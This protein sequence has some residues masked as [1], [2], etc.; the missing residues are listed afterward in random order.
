[1]KKLNLYVLVIVFIAASHSALLAQTKSAAREGEPDFRL[2]D[3]AKPFVE[4]EMKASA[5]AK[6]DLNGD[7]TLDYILVLEQS[8][9]EDTE[10]NSRPALI[11]V[12]DPK[13]KLSLAARNRFVIA[14]RG[15]IGGM[16][17]PFE[18][19][20]VKPGGF[21]ITNKGGFRDRWIGR[22]DFEFSPR[23]KTWL[24]AQVREANYESADPKPV[25][26]KTY[27][28]KHF[29]KIR[30]DDFNPEDFPGT[31]TAAQ[32]ETRA[33]DIYTL[34][35]PDNDYAAEPN[36]VRAV[37][38]VDAK[39]PLAGA[40][41]AL[42]AA[43]AE[44][45][46]SSGFN[47]YLD[48]L[49]FVSARIKNGTARLDFNYEQD[50]E[51]GWLTESPPSFPV[52]VKKTATQFPQVERVLMCINGYDLRADDEGFAALDCDEQWRKK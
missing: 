2:P 41:K 18:S 4:A 5:Y 24:L 12:R 6:A 51:F 30:F 32:N 20:T 28:P 8:I 10:M 11:I 45:K 37:R 36:I 40:I 17:D 27:T 33:V 49:E 35:Y 25:W 38:R 13:G 14:C 29:G 46:G 43:M 52:I 42:L 44:N 15:C 16:S 7:G 47:N 1:M 19:L 31:G 34:E 39:A 21:S 22:Y 9:S 50:T 26:R 23:D 48:K 3:E